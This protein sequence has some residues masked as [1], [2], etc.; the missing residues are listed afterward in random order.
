MIGLVIIY[1]K[2]CVMA[3][4]VT[5]CEEVRE[6]STSELIKI[7]EGMSLVEKTRVPFH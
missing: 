1:L 2:A 7:I 5:L 4:R 3:D 6:N